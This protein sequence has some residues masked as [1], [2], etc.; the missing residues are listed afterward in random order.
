MPPS[1]VTATA[2]ALTRLT[3]L[4]A[5]TPGVIPATTKPALPLPPDRKNLPLRSRANLGP[6]FCK[7]LHWITIA[8]LQTEPGFFVDARVMRLD[9]AKRPAVVLNRTFFSAEPARFDVAPGDTGG[10]SGPQT[11]AGAGVAAGE[12]GPPLAGTLDAA[13]EVR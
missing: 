9:L 7:D 13:G 1:E 3:P 8:R 5:L 2:T 6:V 12:A 11:G 4:A 10:P